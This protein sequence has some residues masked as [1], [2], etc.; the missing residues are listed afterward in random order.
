MR[1]YHYRLSSHSHRAR[2]FLSLPDPT[3]ELADIALHSGLARAPEGNVDP[4]ALQPTG[5]S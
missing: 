1:L 2:L 3:H 4:A 5:P